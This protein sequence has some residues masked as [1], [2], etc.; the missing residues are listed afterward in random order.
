M[1]YAFITSGVLLAFISV[2]VYAQE[3]VYTIIDAQGR[4][5]IL[6]SEA[7]SPQV[8]QPKQIELTPKQESVSETPFKKLDD[9][10]Y[11]DSDYLEKKSFNIDDKKRFYY[12]PNGALGQQVIESKNN[13]AA[14]LPATSV[15]KSK[16]REALYAKNYRELTKEWLIIQHPAVVELCKNPKKIKKYVREFDAVNAL[17]LGSD[18]VLPKKIDKVLKF[19]QTTTNQ[20]NLRISSFATTNK[21]PKFY[22]PIVTFLDE[23]GCIVSG[24]WNY[25]SK[26]YE[27]NNSFFSAV[28]GL[29]SVPV[30]TRYLVFVSPV[31]E[32]VADIP[33]QNAGSFIVEYE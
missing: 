8:E 13:T 29:L 4:P 19:T 5:Q 30:A 23:Q 12:V 6:K 9:E 28:E 32:L 2:G 11:I 25:W 3:R 21:N 7:A 27:A 33:Q 18:G 22:L 1:K 16:K 24:A 26:A 20:Q 15:V 17:W 14:A 31:S 10:V